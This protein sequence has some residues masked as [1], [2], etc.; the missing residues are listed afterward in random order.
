[1]NSSPVSPKSRREAS[2]YGKP[3]KEVPESYPGALPQTS[4]L[5]LGDEVLPLEFAKGRRLGRWRIRGTTASRD[6]QDEG[7][8]LD[9]GLL[10]AKAVPV[11][12]RTPVLAVGS[13]ASP[14]QL[15][16]KLAQ[17]GDLDI[18]VVR[19]STLGLDLAFSAHINPAGYI[20]AAVR[21]AAGR[22]LHVWVTLLDDDQL[23]AMDSTEP[24]YERVLIANPE[25]AVVELESGEKLAACSV[26]RTRWGVLDLEASD[27]DGLI[28]QR[29]LR[30]RIESRCL[31]VIDSAPT[32]P[33]FDEVPQATLAVLLSEVPEIARSKLVVDD[34]LDAL[35]L[36]APATYGQID[37]SYGA[38][39]RS[40]G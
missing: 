9:D 11:D 22:R 3:P 39:A 8:P 17:F 5:L 20:P 36:T 28:S 29:A 35:V 25:G 4:Y 7:V 15:V 10:R 13:N 27:A 38:S 14:S 40:R 16:K 18:P 2:S 23:K 24:N 37:S 34:G 33:G 32:L 1:M 21:C 12:V 31:E 30:R 19:A 6:S 26:Y